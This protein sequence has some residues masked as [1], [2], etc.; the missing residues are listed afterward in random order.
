M[1]TGESFVGLTI[2]LPV[3]LVNAILIVLPTFILRYNLPRLKML[4]K[5]NLRSKRKVIDDERK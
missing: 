5:L 1:F 4:H 2:G 3:A